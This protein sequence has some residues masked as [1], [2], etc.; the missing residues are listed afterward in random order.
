[1]TWQALYEA[2]GGVVILDVAVESALCQVRVRYRR[3]RQEYSIVIEDRQIYDH[4]KMSDEQ[5][6]VWAAVAQP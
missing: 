4:S 2:L 3:K 5:R 6:D 1:M